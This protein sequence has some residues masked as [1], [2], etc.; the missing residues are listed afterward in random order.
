M[1]KEYDK[2]EDYYITKQ[3]AL[4]GKIWFNIRCISGSLISMHKRLKD[5]KWAFNNSRLINPK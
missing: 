2:N 3:T 4:D 5:A 1:R